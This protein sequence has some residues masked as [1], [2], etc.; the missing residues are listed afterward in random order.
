ML[1]TVD[2]EILHQLVAQ[3]EEDKLSV[4]DPD[5]V[6]EIVESTRRPREKIPDVTQRALPPE[7]VR[8]IIGYIQKGEFKESPRWARKLTAHHYAEKL[9]KGALT[10]KQVDDCYGC[11]Q[12]FSGLFQDAGWVAFLEDPNIRFSQR[13]KVLRLSGDNKLVLDLIY[14]LLNKHETD[15]LPGI[16]EEYHNLLQGISIIRAEVTTAVAI[17]HAYEKKIIRYLERMFDTRVFPAFL[18]DPKI[19][20]GIV[21]RVGDKVLDHSLRSRLLQLSKTI[22]AEQ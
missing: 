21:I 22:R 20:G 7:I 10:A 16:V 18:V 13:N 9:F 12:R 1:V 19:L 15:L 5:F 14:R 17:D 6:R 3:I 11:L 2:K 4:L 8:E